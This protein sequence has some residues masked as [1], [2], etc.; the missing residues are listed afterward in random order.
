VDAQP[1]VDGPEMTA[2]EWWT[3]RG[4]G[5]L[6]GIFTKTGFEPF[7]G[8]DLYAGQTKAAVK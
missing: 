2:E 6:P 8:G 1:G 3:K 5:Q 7:T 4:T